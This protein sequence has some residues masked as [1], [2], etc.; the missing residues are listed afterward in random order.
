M[1]GNNRILAKINNFG[2]SSGQPDNVVDFVLFYYC[3]G[4][5]TGSISGETTVQADA[6]QAESLLNIA[7]KTALAAY[8]DPIVFPTQGYTVS[9]V[10]LI[11]A[12]LVQTIS[13]GVIRT[14]DSTPYTISSISAARVNYSINVAWSVILNTFT[15]QAFLEYSTTGSG[16]P[17]ILVNQCTRSQVS[18]LTS[19]GSD[20]LNLTGEMPNGALVRIRSIATNCTVTYNTG[21]EVTY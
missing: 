2:I 17:W 6:T 16:G 15:G 11:P 3:S 8:V 1:A 14:I 20:D 18:N 21:Q 5:L 7:L 10:V 9:D 19:N 4:G 13:N 12:R